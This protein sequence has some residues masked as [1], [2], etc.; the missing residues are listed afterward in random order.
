MLQLLNTLR[1]IWNSDS[2]HPAVGYVRHLQW[3]IRRLFRR[4]PV[5]LPI[6]K[7]VLRVD[8]AT[9]VAALVNAMGKYDYNNMSFVAELLTWFGG[10]FVD[11][12]ANIGTYTLVASEAQGARVI[13]IE[14]HPGTFSL[15]L[16]NVRRNERRTVTC[17][18][19]ALSDHDGSV[20]LTDAPE[21]PLNRVIDSDDE[22]CQSLTVP[23]WTMSAVCRELGVEPH[24]VK[25]DVEGHERAVLNGLGNTAT[26]CKAIFVEGGERAS[27]RDWMRHF[28]FMGPLFVHFKK[29]LLSAMPQP[30]AEDPLFIH[31]SLFPLLRH[32]N[33]DL[34]RSLG[35]V[36]EGGNDQGLDVGVQEH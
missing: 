14:P 33:F 11:V 26:A 23:C 7:S 34:P 4:F 22:T 28:G 24:F 25:I 8:K 9:G 6:S 3:Q 36:S 29:H 10:T 20:R 1:Q 18:N 2:V 35:R 13:S 21:S 27:I 16:E 30:R 19:V 12:G 31:E 32:M 15:L 5:D 17:L